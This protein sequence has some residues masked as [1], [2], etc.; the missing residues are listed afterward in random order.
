MPTNLPPEAL[1]AEEKYRQAQTVP[2]KI[3][4]LEAYISKIPKHKGTDKLRADLRKRLSKLREAGKSQKG[5]ARHISPYQIK[6]EGAGQVLVIGAPNT[7][8]SA[9]VDALTNA[10]PEV[11]P[12]PFSTWGPTPGMMAF[13]NIQVQLIDTPPLSREHIEP[14]MMDLIRRADLVLLVVDLQGFPIEELEDSI[15]LLAEQRIVP[16]HRRDQYDET[17]R[18]FF[19]PLL[20]VVNKCDDDDA[21]GDYEV[22]CELLPDEWPLLPVSANTGRNLNMLRR[23]VFEKLE[24][25]RVYSKPPG[26]EA[27]LTSP[28]VLP[29][30]STVEEFAGEVHRDFIEQLKTARLWGTGVYDGQAVGRD[31]VLHDG[32]IVELHV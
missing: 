29:R 11:A 14:D 6:P 20:V 1:A 21:D 26:K 25:I 28:F 32:D 13:E 2:E 10:T 15:T 8:K 9:L 19:V 23:T 30:S 7:G 22:L 3:A 5:V 4:A 12:F 18:A 27:D 31:H 24:I 16:A 17:E